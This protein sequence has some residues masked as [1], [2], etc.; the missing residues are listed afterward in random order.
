MRAYNS[1]A[2]RFTDSFIPYQCRVSDHARR[3][4]TEAHEGA[5]A[6][7]SANAYALMSAALAARGD[8]PSAY[9]AALVA[10]HHPELR[11]GDRSTRNPEIQKQID[12]LIATFRP[13]ACGGGNQVSP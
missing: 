6:A 2:E 8:W 12:T 13:K 9:A 11:P 5:E 4:P 1:V 7:R 3:A 10:D